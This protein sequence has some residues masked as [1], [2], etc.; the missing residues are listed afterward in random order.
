MNRKSRCMHVCGRVH[1]MIP[2]QVSFPP[3]H[4]CSLQV[5]AFQCLQPFFGTLLAFLVLSEQPT[6]WDMGAIAIVAGLLLVS[7]DRKDAEL[8]ALIGRIRR[9]VS[10]K[11]LTTLL[12]VL[13]SGPA[14]KQ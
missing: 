8:G 10:S 2:W 9:M 6:W 13:G 1:G 14:A 3:T 12:P 4:S 7:M 11:N 5:A